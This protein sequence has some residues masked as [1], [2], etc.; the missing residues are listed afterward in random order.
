MTAPDQLPPEQD[1]DA[2]PTIASPD[3]I[4]A[5]FADRAFAGTSWTPERRGYLY[6][7]DYATGVNSLYAELWPLAKTP[8]QRTLLAAEMET[9]R[10]GSLR[11]MNAYLA[12]HANVVS[13][14]IAGPSKFPAERMRKRSDAADRKFME[15][16]Q[17]RAQALGGHPAQ[18]P[19]RQ[20]RGNPH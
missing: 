9:F 16:T 8:E 4:D 18:A 2:A 10:T 3:D 13:S 7:E 6:R 11:R 15:Y 1:P 12:S 14:F 20:A 19:F 17:W 5:A